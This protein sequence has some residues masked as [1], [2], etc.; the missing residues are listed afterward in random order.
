[1]APLRNIFKY[2]NPTASLAKEIG[3]SA[4]AQ[5]IGSIA[6]L[7]L[8]IS[9]AAETVRVN[10]ESCIQLMDQIRP[11]HDHRHILMYRR[12]GIYA[13]DAAKSWQFPQNVVKSIFVHAV[14]PDDE[15]DQT[16]KNFIDIADGELHDESLLKTL[17][18]LTGNMPLAVSL[19]ANIASYEGCENSLSL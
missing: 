17:L 13:Q 4:G 15:E 18:Q 3:K 8:A 12:R 10:K 11:V 2:T 16:I 1:M 19:I 9:K 7:T 5:F 6:S 14:P